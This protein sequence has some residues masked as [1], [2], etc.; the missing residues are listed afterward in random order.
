MNKILKAVI[1]IAL[2]ILT[3]GAGFLVGMNLVEPVVVEKPVVTERLVEIEVP[4][5]VE[6]E[7]IKEVPIEV[8]VSETIIK[9]IVPSDFLEFL[10]ENISGDMFEDADLIMERFAFYNK[11]VNETKSFVENEFLSYLEDEDVFD[12]TLDNY[13]VSEV[14]LYDVSDVEVRNI[15]YEDLDAN[16]RV[17]FVIRAKESGE[18]AEFFDFR[19]DL[20]FREGELD[21]DFIEFLDRN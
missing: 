12:N 1:G 2:G 7:V 14:S 10:E 20:E 13:R 15:D 6:K 8:P 19:F 17:D 11:V 18:D 3:L 16:T 4:V 9:E 21:L 5:I